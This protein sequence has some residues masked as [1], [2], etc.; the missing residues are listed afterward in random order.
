MNRDEALEL[1]AQHLP[2]KN[3]IKHSIAVE[4][5]MRKMAQFLGEKDEERWAMSGLLH[6]LDYEET[7]DDFPKH[8]L[9]TGEIL[10][11]LG[12]DDQEILDAIVMHS[13]NVPA[14]TNMGKALYAVDPALFYPQRETV[15]ER[16]EDRRRSPESRRQNAACC[17]K[18]GS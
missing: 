16:A 14:T 11:K 2:N 10:K 9:L 6:D 1:L 8:G 17:R 15:E 12:F 18:N 13:G 3:L 4:A 7:K 5:G